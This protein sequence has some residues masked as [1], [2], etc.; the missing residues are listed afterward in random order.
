VNLSSSVGDPKAQ[1][2]CL[3][4][5]FLAKHFFDSFFLLGCDDRVIFFYLLSLHISVWGLCLISDKILFS[6]RVFTL[7]QNSTLDAFR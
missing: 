7:L 2:Q 4:F 3:L 6:Q 1:A 5:A